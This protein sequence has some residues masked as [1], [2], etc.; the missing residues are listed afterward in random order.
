MQEGRTE[1]ESSRR[2]VKKSD[3]RNVERVCGVLE[4]ID[5]RGGKQ[6]E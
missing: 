3:R 1:G 6:G 2:K 5:L 4:D